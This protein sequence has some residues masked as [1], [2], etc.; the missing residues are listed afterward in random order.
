M[1]KPNYFI[2][3]IE[4]SGQIFELELDKLLA[5]D[6]YLFSDTYKFECKYMLYLGGAYTKL[7]HASREE[8]E[9]IGVGEVV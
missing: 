6:R 5:F 3:K 9:R 8:G 2:N 4:L 7:R 1:G